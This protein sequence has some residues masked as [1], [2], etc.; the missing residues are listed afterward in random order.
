M[1]TACDC[2]RRHADLAGV[3]P[4]SR[5][6]DERAVGDRYA[7]WFTRGWMA[8]VMRFLFSPRGL[9][10]INT[11]HR[12]ILDAAQISNEDRVLD[13]GC[14]IGNLLIPLARAHRFQSKPVGVDVSPGVIELARAAT[15]RS[16]LSDRIDYMVAPATA[17]PFPNRRFS[18]VISSHMVKHLDERALETAFNEA[19]RVLEPGGRFLLWEF[20]PS[21]RSAPIFWSARASGIPPPFILREPDQLEAA[22]RRAGFREVR[23]LKTGLFLMPPAPRLALLAVR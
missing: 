3:A 12:R 9:W 11:P 16:D 8:G 1:D 18:V 4:V 10:V 20:K 6:I 13:L 19:A 22:L 17:L 23:Q 7:A 15:A 21:R 2:G 14:G 5:R